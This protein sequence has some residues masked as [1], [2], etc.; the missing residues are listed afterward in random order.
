MG[1]WSSAC[2]AAVAPLCWESKVM[3]LCIG[4]ADSIT[5]LPHQGYIVRTQPSTHLQSD[6]FGRFAVTEGAKSLFI[7]MPQ[8]PFTGSTIQQVSDY[9]APHGI[10]VG[11][12]IYDASKTSFR[13]EVDMAMRAKPDMM[14]LGGYQNDLIVVAKDLYRAGYT[15]K[16]ICY[17]YGLTPPFVEAV[18]RDIAEGMCSLEPISDE[19][20]TAYKRLQGLLGAGLNIYSCQ[21]YDQ[22]NLA[23]LSMAAAKMASG[24]AIRDTVRRIGDPSGEKVDNAPDGLK[25]LAGGK[26]INYLGASSSCKFAP[27]GDVLETHFRINVVHGGKIE[28]LRVT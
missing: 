20:S 24:T 28:T 22:A 6:Q 7:L 25:A 23:V 18:G 14:M 19:N 5:A 3:L 2:T 8:T 21:G 4:A 16:I 11:S 1:T 9:C 13:S 17:A 27:N 10:K 12:M 15:G 26:P